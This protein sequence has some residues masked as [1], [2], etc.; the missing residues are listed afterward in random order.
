MAASK[1]AWLPSCLSAAHHS[2]HPRL[3]CPRQGV[4]LGVA[5]DDQ[6]DLAG[7]QVPGLLGVQQGLEIGAAAGD[8]HGDLRL[9]P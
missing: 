5:G 8:Q 4:G 6:H 2:G 1:A 9:S 3:G 7:G